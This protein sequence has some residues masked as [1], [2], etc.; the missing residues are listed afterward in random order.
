M[1]DYNFQAGWVRRKGKKK[2]NQLNERKILLIYTHTCQGRRLSQL[3]RNT[4]RLGHLHSILQL[5]QSFQDSVALPDDGDSHRLLGKAP[6][7]RLEPEAL[8]GGP[9]AQRSAELNEREGS[10]LLPIKAHRRDQSSDQGQV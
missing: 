1:M 6:G 8:V 4:A 5:S 2:R 7:R 3:V 9:P 10:T